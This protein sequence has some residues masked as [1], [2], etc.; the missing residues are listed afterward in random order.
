MRLFPKRLAFELV[1]PKAVEYYGPGQEPSKPPQPGDFI[2]LH[3]D[4]LFARFIQIGQRLRFHGRNRRYCHWNHAAL[5][6]GDNS[7]IVEALGPRIEKG[8]LSKY[9]G[10]DYQLVRINADAQDRQEAARFALW[11][12]PQ[13][14]G[15]L[16]I[17]SIAFTLLTGCKFS[18]MIDGQE[19][20]SGLVARALE[21]TA[22]IF[23]R[24]PSHVTPADLAKFFNVTLTRRTV[25]EPI[26]VGS[27]WDHSG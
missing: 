10:K 12:L 16:T 27:A 24:D 4:E 20:C 26:A 19:I 23:N 13:P 7:E 1:E 9:K 6:V 15:Y 8:N 11:C 5:I 14:Y 25:A 17:A 18:F 2:L 22:A 21:R 3:S